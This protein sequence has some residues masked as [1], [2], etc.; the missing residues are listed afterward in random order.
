VN[1]Q[2][3]LA[4]LL[5]CT[6]AGKAVRI[7]AKLHKEQRRKEYL[8]LKTYYSFEYGESPLAPLLL[9][10]SARKNRADSRKAA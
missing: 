10:V 1:G 2:S 3:T 5:L 6:S 7:D 4:A 8:L 9:C